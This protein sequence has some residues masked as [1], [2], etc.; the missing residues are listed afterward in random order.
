MFF[1]FINLLSP[2]FL[3]VVNASVS[4]TLAPIANRYVSNMGDVGSDLMVRYEEGFKW[5][6]F[7]AFNL[8]EIPPGSSVDFVMLKLKTQLV[9]K[10]A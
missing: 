1:I 8:S 6:S 2:A 3:S 7:L 4:V 9:L 5:I 10:R